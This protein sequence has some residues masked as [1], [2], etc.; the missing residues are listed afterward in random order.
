MDTIL[1]PYVI[2]GIARD[3]STEDIKQAYRR[4]A[5]RLHPDKNPN[6]GAVAQLQDINAAYEL[7]TDPERHARYRDSL[8]KVAGDIPS[9]FML[10]V[11]PSKRY[12]QPLEESQVVYLLAETY[13]HQSTIEEAETR[14]QNV[15]LNLTLLLDRSNSMN[16]SRLERVKAAAHQIID[17]M[18]ENDFLSIV[19]FN[20]FAEVVVEA[21]PVE[22]RALMKARVAMIRASGGTEI[23]RGLRLAVEQCRS[24]RSNRYVNHIIMLTDGNTY[25][26]QPDCLTLADEITL[27]GIGISAM[28]IGQE[29][30]DEFL[31]KL[32]S[33]TGG[34]AEYIMSSSAVQRFLNDHVR[35]LAN[36]FAERL[37]IS[38]A[39]DA[40]IKLDSAFKLS[41][42]PQPLTIEKPTIPVGNL[43]YHK[44]TAVLFQLELPP[45]LPEG[46]RFIARISVRGDIL[47]DETIPFI[48]ISDISIGVSSEPQS[49]EPPANV[50]DALGKL[51]LYRMQERA[52]EAIDRGD[53]KEA[54]RRLE[55]LATRLL[56]QG[57]EELAQQAL[58]EARQ[59]AYT[60]TLS[61]KG[62]KTLKYQTRSLLLGSGTSNE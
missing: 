31:D 29:W 12:V 14:R 18:G 13:T 53:A 56:E 35:N 26:D 48:A 45:K 37:H 15:R 55:N 61:D 5:M 11:T 52:R 6:V 7:L 23:L 1:D 36:T 58:A 4:V 33:I 8:R 47:L 34:G 17:A 59:V 28:G 39:P 50:V 46:F 10:R 3:A 44:I 22:N 40:E 25:G 30:N 20:D 49:E 38:I 2:L 19:T 62:R 43:Q 60:S 16:G 24:K 54:T 21:S 42:R 51:T 41:P 9:E 57:Q 32:T 27:E